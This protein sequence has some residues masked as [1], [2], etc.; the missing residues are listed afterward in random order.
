MSTQAIPGGTEDFRDHI[1]TIS[2]DGDRA[3]IYPKKPKGKHYN[4]RTIVSIVLLATGF[5]SVCFGHAYILRFHYSLH[6]NFRKSLVRLGMPS[7]N[8]H[9]I[10]FS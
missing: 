9:G 2:E 6:C 8:F 4:K 7:N 5:F 3:W 1:S 10:G